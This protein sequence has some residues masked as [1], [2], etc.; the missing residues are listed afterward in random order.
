MTWDLSRYD[1]TKPPEQQTVVQSYGTF[2]HPEGEVMR[3]ILFKHPVTGERTMI[4]V[5]DTH[6]S[7]ANIADLAQPK[8]Q[9]I[10]EVAPSVEE[11]YGFGDYVV[12]RVSRGQYWSTTGAAE[13]RVKAAGGP[14][15]DKPVVATFKV[16][17][18]TSTYRYKNSL[19]VL[20]AIVDQTTTG[21]T[22]T[23]A[24]IYDLAD[25]SRPRLASRLAVPFQAFRYYGFVCGDFWGGYWFGSGEQTLVTG[26][27]LAQISYAY[28]N[29]GTTG[30]S[31]P[32]LSFL[33][34]RDRQ[35]TAGGPAR[36]AL[37]QAVL[38][39]E[40]PRGRSRLPGGL[41]PR[42]ARLPRP[43]GDGNRHVQPVP[44]LR[45]ALRARRAGDPGGEGERQ[46]TGTAGPDVARR[47]RDAALP[48]QRLHLSHALVPGPHGVARGHPP[49]PAPA[50]GN[51]EGAT[52]L[53]THTFADA[54]VGSLVLDG[55]RLFVAAQNQYYWWSY[56]AERAANPPT[57]ESTSD[58][59][60]IFNVGG[61]GFASLYDQPT[62]TYGVQLMGMHQGKLFVACRTT[63]C[64]PRTSTDPAHPQSLKFLRTLGWASHLGF[65][66][67]DAYV[68][69]GSF[70]VFNLNL[71]A[72]SVI[73]TGM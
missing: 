65:N 15:D 39:L 31:V 9:S 27:G 2:V 29:D 59:L 6:L 51:V 4:N 56:P 44:V 18:A 36:A 49:G 38:G 46:P 3:S 43:G 45:A 58:R 12:E 23:E 8:L 11:I 21:S 72:P 53:D 26:A 14:I 64:S 28:R 13:F 34:L 52:L 69:A 19:V 48:D 47:R 42:P 70:G 16:G 40:R 10:V 67:N 37:R 17:Q 63:A 22:S 61:N 41:L 1:A 7:V 71:A 5:S 73:A 20:R 30:W 50:G 24:V 25:P 33:D 54:Y 35:R 66:G 57:W 62:R 68:A 32:T 55:D 60:L